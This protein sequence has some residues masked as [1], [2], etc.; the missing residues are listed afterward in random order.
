MHAYLKARGIKVLFLPQ[1]FPQ[2]DF[3]RITV[4]LPNENVALLGALRTYLVVRTFF[5][6]D[7]Q[8]LRNDLAQVKQSKGRV[9]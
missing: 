9:N 8:V 6:S 5:A 1:L 3:L 2:Q 4:G 7:R